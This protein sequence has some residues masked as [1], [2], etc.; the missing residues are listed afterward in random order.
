L[1]GGVQG[2]LLN[3]KVISLGFGGFRRGFA[4][5]LVVFER[6]LMLS[7]EDR[8]CFE[9]VLLVFMFAY[10]AFWLHDCSF[11]LQ[12]LILFSM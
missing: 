4:C 11:L 6:N 12:N 7:D 2:G 8:C 9:S 1:K 5:V 10:S 3:F